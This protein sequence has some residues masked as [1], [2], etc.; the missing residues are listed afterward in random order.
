VELEYRGLHNKVMIF[1]CHWFD[2]PGGVKIDKDHSI[3]E[4]K[5]NSFLKT[6]EPFVFAAQATQVYY[7]SYPSTKRERRNW[8]VVIKIKVKTLPSFSLVEE[9]NNI[10]SNVSEFFQEDGPCFSFMIDTENDI[11]KAL[12]DHDVVEPLS[13]VKIEFIMQQRDNLAPEVETSESEYGIDSEGEP[14][15]DLPDDEIDDESQTESYSE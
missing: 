9:N 4:V 3:V 10:A 11:P 6:Y 8:W 12:N 2:V 5:C 1:K 15:D 7:L 14:F 13:I